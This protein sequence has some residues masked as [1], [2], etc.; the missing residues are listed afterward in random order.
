MLRGHCS[1]SG[2]SIKVLMRGVVGDW[3]VKEGEARDECMAGFGE[4]S[5]K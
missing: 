1:C 3:V 4:G 5:S 2:V